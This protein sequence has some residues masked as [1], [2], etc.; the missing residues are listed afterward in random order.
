M[1]AQPPFRPEDL[2]APAREP[3]A[4]VEFL[5]QQKEQRYPDPPTFYQALCRGELTRDDLLRWVKDQYVYWDHGV[6]YSTAAI[7]TKTNDEPTRTHI[8]RRMVDIEGKDVVQ[9]L[10]GRTT[11]SWE[12]LWLQFGASL[13][14]AEAEIVSAKPFTRTHF[15]VSTLCT[16]SRYWDWTWLD[17]IAT[18]YAADLCGQDYLQQASEA[19]RQHYGVPARALEFFRVYLEDVRSHIPWEEEALAYWACTT[20]RQL[21]AARA[22]RERLDIEH[23]LLFGLEKSLAQ[24]TQ[25]FAIP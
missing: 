15:A 17:G 20:E 25:A 3:R 18:F 7:F 8:L 16:Y 13:G 12:S 14:L 11:P 9:D 6:V 1:G 22:F 4:F 5:R 10:S 21:T 24:G 23:Q 2:Q 19:L